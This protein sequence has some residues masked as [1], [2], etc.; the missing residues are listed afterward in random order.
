MSLQQKLAEY[1][2]TRTLASGVT[3]DQVPLE[4]VVIFR[5]A[6][7]FQWQLLDGKSG[8]P[9]PLVFSRSQISQLSS[10]T[11]A[12]GIVMTPEDGHP[13]QCFVSVSSSSENASADVATFFFCDGA[14]SGDSFV[15]QKTD[16][17]QIEIIFNVFKGEND[18]NIF[19]ATIS[20][21]QKHS[22]V[23][24]IPNL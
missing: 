23:I 15:Y 12:V 10:S 3:P 13:S 7:T 20:D 2:K 4:F 8:K 17:G 9:R 21:N 1:L 16:G 14:S 18:A 6:A 22:V 5:P 19:H 11:D 24:Q